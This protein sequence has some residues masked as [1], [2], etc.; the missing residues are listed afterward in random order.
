MAL[1]MRIKRTLAGVEARRTFSH[2][3]YRERCQQERDESTPPCAVRLV[4]SDIWRV[5]WSC[6]WLHTV[7]DTGSHIVVS[8]IRITIDRTVLLVGS[9]PATVASAR[10]VANEMM[11]EPQSRRVVHFH[12]PHKEL[13]KSQLRDGSAELRPAASL[14]HIVLAAVLTIRISLPS[15]QLRQ[16]QRAREHLLGGRATHIKEIAAELCCDRRVTWR[17]NWLGLRRAARRPAHRAQPGEKA[18]WG[19]PLRGQARA[20]SAV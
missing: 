9:G 1:T 12:W 20:T 15:D 19:G 6:S 3:V 7:S 16:P 10:A 5:S 14:E 2:S 11:N 4:R 18:R 13:T 17:T 8:E